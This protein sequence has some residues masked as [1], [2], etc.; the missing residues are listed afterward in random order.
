MAKSQ[1]KGRS[2]K[3]GP[4]FETVDKQER[5]SVEPRL[6]LEYRE[7]ISKQLM[8]EFGY[9]NQMEVP[10]LQKITINMGLGA[11]VSNP[12]MV[13]G[14]VD[15]MTVLSGQKAVATRARIAIS[16]FKLR[17]GMPIGCMVT[18]RR[19]RMWEFL[20]RL[21]SVALPRVRDFKGIS[22]KAF[23]GRGNYSL[24]LR[25]Q[26]V[27]PEIEYDKIE[28]VKGMNISIVTTA[29]TNEEAKALLKSLGMPFRN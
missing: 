16:N 4:G 26:G 15:E 2:A 22:G 7:K 11:A 18:L 28:H 21:I 8:K 20:D 17:E 3:K 14:A 12:N 25:E 27:F 24:G 5:A 6:L 9:K 10:R 29:K 23:D 13:Q 19:A 1:G